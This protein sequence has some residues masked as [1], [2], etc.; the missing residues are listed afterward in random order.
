MVL[1]LVVGGTQGLRDCGQAPSGFGFPGLVPEIKF[2]RKPPWLM[3]SLR[4]GGLRG[5]GNFR[6]PPQCS[7]KVPESALRTPPPYPEGPVPN[8]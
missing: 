5:L 6:L 3:D 4:E 2:K 7:P 1:V 8:Y